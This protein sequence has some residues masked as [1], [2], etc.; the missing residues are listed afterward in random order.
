MVEYH[1]LFFTFAE[2]LLLTALP[3]KSKILVTGGAGFIGCN[4]CEEF[5]AQD[6]DVFCLD[7]FSTGKR[8]NIE[9]FLG[10]EKFHLIVG[11]ITNPETCLSATS[12]INYVFH[13]AALGSVPRSIENPVAT[14]RANIDGFLNVLIA[15]R[16]NKVKRLIYASSS[17]VY[18]DNL[19]F[20]K[21][22]EKTGHP[23]SPYAVTK[24]VNELYAKVFAELYGMEVIGLRYFNVFGK[25]QDPDGP[26]AAAIPKFIKSY[27]SGIAPVIY[28]DGTQSRDFTYIENVVHANILAAITTH[29]TAI[30]NVFN[31]ACGQ[32]T[33]VNDLCIILSNLLGTYK[34]E[35]K[36][37]KPVYA[38]VRKG[39]VK[40]SLASLKKS[41]ELLGYSP[42]CGTQKGLENSIQWYINNL[43]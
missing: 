35:I 22:E 19:D 4:L 25:Y 34:P 13:Q 43:S 37:I 31:V 32:K 24:K 23:L 6:H 27:L 8:K 7:N 5:L 12:G 33:S 29:K 42:V 39:D 9:R 2:Y 14:H 16:D 10:N 11:D 3:N 38:P 26:Y 41:G 36:K 21:E 28:G 1:I 40:N 20:P 18:G 30:G 17:S 15:C